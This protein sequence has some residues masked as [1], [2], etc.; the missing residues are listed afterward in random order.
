M[1]P[2]QIK[3][4]KNHIVGISDNDFPV[5]EFEQIKLFECAEIYQS[6]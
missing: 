4:I 1:N 6:S 3:N 5:I 2:S